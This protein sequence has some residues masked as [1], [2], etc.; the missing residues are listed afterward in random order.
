MKAFRYWEQPRHDV[1]RPPSTFAVTGRHAGEW[2][3][4]AEG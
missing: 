3:D 1:R 2:G 4:G